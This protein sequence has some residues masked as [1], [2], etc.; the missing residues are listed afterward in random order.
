MVTFH[1]FSGAFDYLDTLPASPEAIGTKFILYTNRSRMVG[2]I[3]SYDN[4]TS[5]FYSHFDPTKPV[6]VIIHGFGSSG[7]KMWVL[8]MA[9]ALLATVRWSNV[10]TL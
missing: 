8:Q 9:E 7:R 6:K 2:D 3:L 10:F 1:F 4:S 5:L